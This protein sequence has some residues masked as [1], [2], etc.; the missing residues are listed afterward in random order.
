M[1]IK[2]KCYEKI[3]YVL[4]IALLLAGCNKSGASTETIDPGFEASQ[5][6]LSP[7]EPEDPDEILKYRREL[8][9]AEMRR[10]M[11]TLW[12]PAEDITY[13]LKNPNEVSDEDNKVLVL[14]AGK[15]YQGVPYTHGSGSGYGFFSYATAQ[16][17]N[18]V[19]TISGLT[20]EHLTGESRDIAGSSA[21]QGNDC[22]DAVYWSWARIC[23]SVTFK[24][25]AEMTP[26]YGI[27]PVGDYVCNVSK[28]TTTTKPIVQENGEEVM[29]DA[30]SKMQPGDAMVLYTKSAGGH[31]VMVVDVQISRT[32]DGKI[33]PGNSYAIIIEQNS[34]QQRN[35][36][37]N[38]H[39]GL[40]TEVYICGE[41]DVPWSFTTLYSKGYLPVTCKELIDPA[42]L[43]P[44][45][46]SLSNPDATIDNLFN[47][48]VE[49]SHRFAYVTVTIQN[50]A[51]IVQQATAYGRET[52]YYRFDMYAFKNDWEKNL[53]KG[54]LDLESLPAGQYKCTVT[55]RLATGNNFTVYEKDF[56]RA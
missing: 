2:E 28:F 43:K 1:P 19:Y 20:G 45:S 34:A 49:T 46:A 12:T 38:Y 5:P 44:Q 47:A 16:D 3:V 55:C 31:A 56:T 42:P 25:A 9:V 23:T 18:G 22:A 53:I 8:V 32:E 6:T 24:Y 50:D 37:S 15:I 36:R 21:R 13:Y 51:G 40:Q 11:G 7:T 30:Y 29:F 27:I 26:Q 52:D 39:E 48:S 10:I 4:L 35:E 17:E 14:Q 54:T 41:M 33:D